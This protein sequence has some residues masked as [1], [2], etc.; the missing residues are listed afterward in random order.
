MCFL[1]RVVGA[2]V[3][4]KQT[5][6]FLT[7]EKYFFYYNLDLYF[8][9]FYFDD[10]TFYFIFWIFKGNFGRKTGVTRAAWPEIFIGKK[11][12]HTYFLNR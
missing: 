4:L 7:R 6:L 1:I 3:N 9:D 10:F 5:S 8:N 12:K 11:S 2:G